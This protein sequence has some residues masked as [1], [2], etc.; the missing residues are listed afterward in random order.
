M[1]LNRC[2]NFAPVLIFS[3]LR[4]YSTTKTH[5]GKGL[6]P[7][8]KREKMPNCSAYPTNHL[9]SQNNRVTP[10]SQRK[11]KFWVLNKQDDLTQP[12]IQEG[13]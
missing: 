1:L 11:T 4:E 13:I 3:C 5:I 6:K 7:N 12:K 10:E 8:K 9:P 2:F